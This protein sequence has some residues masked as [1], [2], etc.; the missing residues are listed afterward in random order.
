MAIDQRFY[1]QLGPHPLR[2]LL[3]L[4]DI[5]A[6]VSEDPVITGISSAAEAL[7]GDICFVDSGAKAASALNPNAAACFIRDADADKLPN[8]VVPIIVP[9][10]RY[11]HKLASHALFELKDWQVDGDAP[12]IHATAS[13]APS[14][15]IGA[16]AA[17]GEAAIISPGA[18]IG[19]GVQ[20]GARTVIGP[21]A[22]VR[23]ALIGNDVSIHA[24]VIVGEAG[25][26]VTPGSRGAEDAPQWGRVI[27]QDFVTIGAN[28]CVDRGAFD[29]T[30][31]GERTKIDN[32]VQ[33][34]HNV[35]IGRNVVIASFTGIS[36]TSTIGDGVA[37]GGQVGVADH[38]HVGAGARIA[39]SAGIMRDVPAGETYGGVPAKPLRQYFREVS[40]L[41]KQVAAKKKPT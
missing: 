34:A 14:A 6:E 41:E 25:F 3:R 8:T 4:C 13:I 7:P 19:P 12:A 5:D 21:N 22:V 17:I 23:C 36:G 20:I 27:I 15:V 2:T 33:I 29:D 28:T 40:W 16:G 31:I 1:T 10:P 39:A 11:A 18:V 37:M 24:G 35:V 30:I 26:G 38:I 9:Q 32:L